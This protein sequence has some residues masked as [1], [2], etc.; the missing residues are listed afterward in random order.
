MIIGDVE[1][2]Q[3]RSHY[4]KLVGS[5]STGV[6]EGAGRQRGREHHKQVFSKENKSCNV[7]VPMR[8]LKGRP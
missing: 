3:S 5:S 8:R 2:A 7:D 4:V 1:K 6:H